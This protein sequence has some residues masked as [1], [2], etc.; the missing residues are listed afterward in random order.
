MHFGAVGVFLRLI[1]RLDT[2]I[3]TEVKREGGKKRRRRKN[4]QRR[5]SRFLRLVER[6]VVRRTGLDFD[7]LRT[8]WEEYSA[9]CITGGVI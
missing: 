7:E 2:G 4:L 1:P 9:R 3:G 6:L 8:D 5:A